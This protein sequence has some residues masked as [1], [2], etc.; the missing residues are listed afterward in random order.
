MLERNKGKSAT[1]TWNLKG[2][3]IGNGWISPLDQ[4]PAYLEYAYEKGL[5]TRDGE[6]AKQLE[7][8]Q[9]VCLQTLEAGGKD[10]VDVAPCEKVLQEL[11]RLT[12]TPGNNGKD[13]CFN[14]YDIR[15]KD[16]FPSCGM[17]WPPD[18]AEV[19]PYLR[20]HDV[21]EALHVIK[22]KKSGWTEC[23]GAVGG[24]FAVENSKPSISFL[25]ELI[26][27]VPI[28][29]FSGEQDLI[30]NHVGTENLI[31]NLNWGGAKGFEVSSGTWAPRQ[32]WT[33]EG[34]DAGFWQSARNL[35]Y[36]LFRGSS[37]MVPYDYARRTRDM[38]DRFMGVDIASIGGKP[39]DSRIDGEKGLETSVGG[40]PNST[41]AAEAEQERLEAAKWAAYYKSGEIVLVI[42]ILAAGIWFWYI[43]KDRRHRSGY[44]G[45]FGGDAPMARESPRTPS[46]GL[47]GFRLK[48][49]SRDV[50]LADFDG[51]TPRRTSF[52]DAG[53]AAPSP[54]H[55]NE[56]YSLGSASDDD[57][58]IDNEPE[59][60]SGTGKQPVR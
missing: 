51:D 13:D 44:K 19:T 49:R 6:I 38:M 30:C 45:I 43:W 7:A 53:S 28:L 57:E 50:E 31:G 12:R 29:L 14:M 21:L 48:S 33:F 16:V 35:T 3:V 10:H 32:A 11:L 36:V 20:Q 58:D 27:Q 42:V 54:L 15:L 40:H 23:N 24:A 37:H 41:A 4:Y 18:L 46:L 8:K 52:K 34:E 5:L 59:K 39:A 26:E 17:N 2:M 56:R 22:E 60:Q 47:E 25:P 55:P 1:D 9:A